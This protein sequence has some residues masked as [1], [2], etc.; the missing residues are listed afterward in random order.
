MIGH[1][2]RMFE[3]VVVEFVHHCYPSVIK[4]ILDQQSLKKKQQKSSF[5]DGRKEKKHLQHC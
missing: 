4:R 3:F 5:I 1:D 2:R